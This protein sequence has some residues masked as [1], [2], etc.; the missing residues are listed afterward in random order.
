MVLNFSCQ[1]QVLTMECPGRLVV[2]DSKQQVYANFSL[3]EEWDGLTVTAIFTNAWGTASYKKLLG[4]EPV[5]IPT[6]VL[7]TPGFRV[8]LHGSGNNGAKR[9]P[10]VYMDRPVAVHRAGALIGMTPEDTM[11]ELWEQVL[12]AVGNLSK[13][14]TEDKSSLVAAINEALKSGGGT[15]TKEAIIAAL[16]YIPMGPKMVQD[17]IKNATNNLVRLPGDSL[18]PEY[19]TAGQFAVSDGKGGVTWEDHVAEDEETDAKFFDIDYDGIVSLKSEYRGHPADATHSYAVSDNGIGVDGS[20]IDELP[21]KIVIPEVINGTAVAGFQPG[22][23]HCNFRVKEIVFPDAVSVIPAS[24]CNEAKRLIKIEN[25]KNI[26]VLGDNAFR[27]T[28][29]QKAL[30]PKLKAVGISVFEQCLYMTIADIGD[31]LE[32]IPYGMFRICMRLSHVNGG[33]SVKTIGERAFYSTH[34]LKN[35]PLLKNVTSVG[36][37]AF[38]TSRIQFDWSSLTGCR[39]GNYATP[40]ADNDV[41]Y[42]TGVKFTPCKNRL[43]TI[44]NQSNPKWSTETFGSTTRTYNNGCVLM[45]MLHIHSAYNEEKTYSHPK[46]FENELG[47]LDPT[48]LSL[49]VGSVSNFERFLNVLGYE[50]AKFTGDTPITQDVL[51]QIYTALSEGAYVV[52]GM[53]R[54]GNSLSQTAQTIN[55]AHAGVAYGV[56]DI[57]ELLVVDSGTATTALDASDDTSLCLYQIPLQNV[58]GPTSDIYIVRKPKAE[59]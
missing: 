16:E 43:G 40:V 57:G 41:D 9:L 56:N 5:E 35:L 49:N 23:F 10:T 13:L 29:L 14:D 46:E 20:K 48:L 47:A 55:G 21:E 8:S 28:S 58:T 36:D 54:I 26:E 50:V 32:E 31:T 18:K 3:D 6:A 45:A 42:W 53:S 15:V 44:V 19:G 38:F 2:A 59:A 30:F 34:S 25:T 17:E 39:F 52:Y 1:K 51:S 33:A 27:R 12:A 11:P 22:M 4:A 37:Y 7:A 24:F